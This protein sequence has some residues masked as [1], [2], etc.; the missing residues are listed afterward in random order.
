MMTKNVLILAAMRINQG[1]NTTRSLV[2]GSAAVL[3]SV[4]DEDDGQEKQ[5][6]DLRTAPPQHVIL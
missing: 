5:T 6:A 1:T 4:F 3:P 2:Q